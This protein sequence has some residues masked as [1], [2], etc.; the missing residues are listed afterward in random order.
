MDRIVR[1]TDPLSAWH[2]QERGLMIFRSSDAEHNTTLGFFKDG[3]VYCHI[4]A[5]PEDAV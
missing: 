2:T 3:V 1:K 4:P 5:F